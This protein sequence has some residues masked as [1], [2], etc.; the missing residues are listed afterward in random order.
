MYVQPH[1]QNQF[2]FC[3]F[4]PSGILGLAVRTSLY[5]LYLCLYLYSEVP[6]ASRSKEEAGGEVRDGR[7][8]RSPVDLYCLVPASLHVA[9]QI[10]G[11]SRQSTARRLIDH[12]TGRL[13]GEHTWA[14]SP[15]LIQLEY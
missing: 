6:S 14:G 1:G 5:Y 11:R 8:D 3:V 4:V 9:H 15:G 2:V 10:C 7:S 13:S 12:H